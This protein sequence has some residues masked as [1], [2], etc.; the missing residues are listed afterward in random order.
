MTGL[1]MQDRVLERSLRPRDRLRR[2]VL[3]HGRILNHG[4]GSKERFSKTEN[5]LTEKKREDVP[6]RKIFIILLEEFR[7][8]P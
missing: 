1:H 7:R 3:S 5:A 4:I 6:G 2:G 8:K